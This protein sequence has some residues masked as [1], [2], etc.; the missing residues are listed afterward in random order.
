MVDIFDAGPTV[1][2]DRDNIRTVR[3]ARRLTVVV[4]EPDA[5]LPAL[6]STDAVRDFRAVRQK[7]AIDGETV[8]ISA[9]TAD[10]LKIRAGDTVRVKT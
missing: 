2:C 9:E 3:D 4:G 5:E 10:A 1:T 7:A 8:T 6:I